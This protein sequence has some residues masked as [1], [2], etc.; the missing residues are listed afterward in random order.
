MMA[1]HRKAMLRNMTI[2]LFKYQRIETLLA[3]A[4]ETRRLAEHMITLAK[5]DTVASRRRAYEVLADRDM[6]GKLFNEIAPLFKDRKSGYTRIIPL[7]F[8]RG[9]GA[10]LAKLELTEKKIEE[11][12]PKKKEKARAEGAPRKEAV[13]PA[14][15][16]PEAVPEEKRK[17]PKKEEPRKKAKPTL[18]EEKRAEKAKTEDKKIEAKKNFMKNLRGFFRRKTDM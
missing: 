7:G 8:R 18:D 6:V 15:A 13:Q 17:E 16:K 2:S 9:D 3:R 4:K 14:A 10:E 12:P 1:A 5:E 11:K